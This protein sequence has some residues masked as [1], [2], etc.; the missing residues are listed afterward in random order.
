MDIKKYSLYDIFGFLREATLELTHS[1]QVEYD[2]NGISTQ[3]DMQLNQYIAMTLAHELVSDTSPM[4]SDITRS[5]KKA[6]ISA[7]KANGY[8]EVAFP[9]YGN[10]FGI[11]MNGGTRKRSYKRNKT[12]KN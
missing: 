9:K 1:V 3:D 8:E 5:T 7:L 10:Y 2:E 4:A 12:Q 11:I 6:V